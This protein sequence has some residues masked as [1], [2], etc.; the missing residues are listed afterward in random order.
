MLI[1]I[2]NIKTELPLSVLLALTSCDGGADSSGPPQQVS[3]VAP[4]P[5]VESPPIISDED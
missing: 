5:A 3:A 2:Q 1:K 4:S